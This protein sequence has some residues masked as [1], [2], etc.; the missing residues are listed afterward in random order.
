[1][2]TLYTIN[3][4]YISGVYLSKVLRIENE[5]RKSINQS[6]R[7]VWYQKS[8]QNCNVTPRFTHVDTFI[9]SLSLFKAKPMLNCNVTLMI[10]FIFSLSLF[11]VKTM[12]NFNTTLIFYNSYTSFSSSHFPCHKPYTWF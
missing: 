12:L 9:F 3:T 5:K 2:D 10:K 1:M 11:N 7:N 6:K 4:I 8:K